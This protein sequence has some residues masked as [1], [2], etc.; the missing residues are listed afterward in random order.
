M[1]AKS[2]RYNNLS[3]FQFVIISVAIYASGA[4]TTKW[5]DRRNNS[6]SLLL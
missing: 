4:L 2:G 3:V 6:R 5:I 1:E